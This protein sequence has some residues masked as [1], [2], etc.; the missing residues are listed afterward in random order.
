MNNTEIIDKIRLELLLKERAMSDVVIYRFL[1]IL[2]TGQQ[3]KDLT[4]LIAQILIVQSETNKSLY[5][6]LLEKVRGF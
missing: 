4:K 3:N 1:A 6:K 2:K 5:D